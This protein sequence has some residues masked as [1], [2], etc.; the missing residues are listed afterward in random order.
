MSVALEHRK[1]LVL[2]KAWVPTG[3]STLPDVITLL[4][5]GD[6]E[7]KAKII[8]PTQEFQ[9]FTW[10]DWSALKPRDGEDV[11]RGVG[12]SFKI[13]EVIMLTG[14][15]KMPVQRVHFS[16][17]TIY[18]RDGHLCQYCGDK[19]GTE[20]TIDHVRPK[21]QGGP[22]TWENCVLAC[23]QCNSQKADRTPELAIRPSGY[24]EGGNGFYF[25]PRDRDKVWKGASPM[26]LRSVPKKPRFTILKGDRQFVPKSWDAFIS[27]IYWQC[28]LENDNKN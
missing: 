22:T 10:D 8:D 7:C 26:K 27:E 24:V 17:R 15:D 23:L 16:R 9:T 25:H 4:W 2:N 13:P 18:R 6:D 11:I 1:V 20:G 28:E 5:R 3:V 12:R 21:S 14:Y 19:V